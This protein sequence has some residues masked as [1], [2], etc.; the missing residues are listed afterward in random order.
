M[1]QT[2]KLDALLAEGGEAVSTVLA[3]V[4]PDEV[5]EAR[6]CGRWIHK[7]SGRSY[8]ATNKK[9]KSLEAAGADAVAADE[10]MKDDETGEQLIQ[11][12]DDTAEALKKR[13][14]GYHGMTVPILEHYKPQGV[15][16][17]VNGNQA[18]DAIWGDIEKVI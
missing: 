15:V 7:P 11:R 14:E 1:E 12:A 13:L 6:I 16:K 5:L 10:N 17:E 4:V 8:H 18:I 2:T 3:L 9:P